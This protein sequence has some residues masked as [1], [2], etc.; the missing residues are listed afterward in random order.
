[1]HAE[2]PRE[3]YRELG[4]KPGEQVYIQPTNARVFTPD[5]QI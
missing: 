3:Q 1:V 4:L 2:L 5:Y